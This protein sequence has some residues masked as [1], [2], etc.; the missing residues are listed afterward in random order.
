ML[1]QDASAVKRAIVAAED[2]WSEAESCLTRF[3]G[4][5]PQDAKEKIYQ[6]RERLAVL[7]SERTGNFN[8]L[9]EYHAD[10]FDVAASLAE[11]SL[12]TDV[13]RHTVAAYLKSK[14]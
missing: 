3:F 6:A 11:V 1:E 9:M 12:N 4:F 5:K 7:D 13:Y 10:P 2:Y 14:S 8:P